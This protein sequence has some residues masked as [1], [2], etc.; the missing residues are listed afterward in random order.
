MWMLEALVEFKEDEHVDLIV[1]EIEVEL[2]EE[3][4]EVE[5]IWR[6]WMSRW[7]SRR[8]NMWI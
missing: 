3:E 7:S 6:C 1:L 4:E 5:V 8:M 2:K